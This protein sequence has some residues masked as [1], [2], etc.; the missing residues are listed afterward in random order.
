MEEKILKKIETFL[1]ERKEKEIF[2]EIDNFHEERIKRLIKNETPLPFREGGKI[3]F[4]MIPFESFYSPKHY[5]LSAYKDK[6]QILKV[7]RGVQE[8]TQTYNFDGLLY[9]IIG[10]GD[11]CF[12]YVQVYTSGLIEAVNGYY[13]TIE[14]KI[15]YMLDIEKEI[16]SNTGEYLLFQKELGINPP[17]IFYLTLLGTKGF[18]MPHDRIDPFTT[19]HPIDREDLG[20]PKIIIEKF[21]IAPEEILKINFDRIWNACGYP[22]SEYY[23][24]NGKRT[25]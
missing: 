16:I 18:S 6:S 5:D 7:L 24:K 3:V 22:G 19:T 4:H 17:I 8:Y 25:K 10:R 14:K 20:L 1:A 13:L 2:Q 11:K 15:L 9:S 23:D 12:G 21:D